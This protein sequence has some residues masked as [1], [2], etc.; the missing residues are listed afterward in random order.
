MAVKEEIK[1]TTA[2]QSTP[3]ESSLQ[4]RRLHNVFCTSSPGCSLEPLKNSRAVRCPIPCDVGF[5][6]LRCIRLGKETLVWGV[7]GAGHVVA[8]DGLARSA[9]VWLG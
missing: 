3:F 1:R 7:A 4:D 2:N 8:C 9:A 6:S 5:L